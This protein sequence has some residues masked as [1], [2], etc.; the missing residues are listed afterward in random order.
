MNFGF[1]GH[2]KTGKSTFINSIRGLRND[3]KLAA[4]VDTIEKTHKVQMYP[5]LEIEF[6]YVRLYDIPGC[7]TI[8]HKTDGYYIDNGLAAFDVLV[9]LVQ[10]TIGT[11]EIELAKFSKEHNQPVMFVRSKMDLNFRNAVENDGIYDKMNQENA[12]K[13]IHKTK[14][15]IHHQLKSQN[16]S[17]DDI[18]CVSSVVMRQMRTNKKVDYHF[19][20]DEFFKALFMKIEV[21]RNIVINPLT[22][23]NYKKDIE[24]DIENLRN[25]VMKHFSNDETSETSEIDDDNQKGPDLPPLNLDYSKIPRLNKEDFQVQSWDMDDAGIPPLNEEENK[26]YFVKMLEF[27]V[28][29]KP[30]EVPAYFP[31]TKKVVRNNSVN[32]F[33][34]FNVVTLIF[35]TS[36][37]LFGI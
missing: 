30:E 2:S 15:H 26:D 31:E 34:C 13:L 27:E 10:D 32:S 8:T 35:I 4:P 3:D 36:V 11:D 9:I 23:N 12:N 37:F 21:S 28:K 33:K 25:S 1:A 6:K 17:G 16:L 14:S 29:D 18:F 7:G 22:L 20:E 5:F 24:K 19:E